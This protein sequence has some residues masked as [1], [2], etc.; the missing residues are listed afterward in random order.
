MEKISV[1]FDQISFCIFKYEIKFLDKIKVERVY[2]SVCE[3]QTK[4]SVI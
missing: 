1:N 3:F 4:S 2:V